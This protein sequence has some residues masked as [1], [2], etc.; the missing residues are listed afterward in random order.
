MESRIKYWNNTYRFNGQITPNSTTFSWIISEIGHKTC[1]R[2][3]YKNESN[4]DG[5]VLIQNVFQRYFST[6][7]PWW[8]QI[9]KWIRRIWEAKEDE[10]YLKK[11]YKKCNVQTKYEI[12]RMSQCQKHTHTH[13]HNQNLSVRWIK[14]ELELQF[15]SKMLMNFIWCFCTLAIFHVENAFGFSSVYL[16]DPY[17][18]EIL[19]TW[20]WKKTISTCTFNTL[21][22]TIHWDFSRYV[23]V[24]RKLDGDE[25]HGRPRQLLCELNW[26]E[27]CDSCAYFEM[28][29]LLHQ[30]LIELSHPPSI[31]SGYTAEKLFIIDTNAY[32]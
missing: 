28:I 27:L 15:R 3:H 12:P 17:L 32:P 6:F 14:D 4:K 26:Y 11:R 9:Q 19:C 22:W 18:S 20:I 29:T 10:K 2:A 30:I 31:D 21:D 16:T 23:R 1:N 24:H 8:S 25:L 5:F 7:Q 13:L